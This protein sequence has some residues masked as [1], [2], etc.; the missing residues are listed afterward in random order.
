MRETV[1]NMADWSWRPIRR[2]PRGASRGAPRSSLM[3]RPSRRG[4]EAGALLSGA[5]C[6][7]GGTSALLI[8]TDTS[9]GQTATAPLTS[10]DISVQ[11]QAACG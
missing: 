8:I 5:V 2:V 10:A 9:T 4:S 11:G 7:C 1:L 3:T 6:G